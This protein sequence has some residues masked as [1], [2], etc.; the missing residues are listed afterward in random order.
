MLVGSV[1]K[2]VLQ[3]LAYA[4]SLAPDRLMAVCVVTN[5]EEQD[6]I[7]KQW[8][9]H[10]IS[11]ELHTLHSAYRE[12]TRPVLRYLD[13]LDS[14]SQDDIITVI[15]PEFVVTHWYTNVLHNQSALALKARL[16]YR[17]NTVVTSVPVIVD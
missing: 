13:E 9:E 15:I 5:Q 6:A 12:L 11:V 14:E 16:L 7:Q 4:R 10:E 17:P 1:N 3:A 2:G 8:A